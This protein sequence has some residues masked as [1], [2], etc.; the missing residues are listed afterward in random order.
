MS[1]EKA[2]EFLLALKEKGADKAWTEKAAKAKTEK[3][4]L[5]VVVDMA[6]EM[7]Y[8]LTAEDIKEALSGLNK[9]E[10]DLVQVEDEAMECVAG[11]WVSPPTEG[12]SII[13]TCDKC[14]NTRLVYTG[15]SR[16][17]FWFSTDYQYKCDK[18][19]HLHWV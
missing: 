7:G 12:S 9:G 3:E 8:D 17:G 2:K 11:G 19:G 15:V 13:F 6:R 5:A 4:K 16:P 1:I 14:G 18:C 10:N